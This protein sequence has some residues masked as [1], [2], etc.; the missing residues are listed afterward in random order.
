MGSDIGKAIKFALRSVFATPGKANELALLS[1]CEKLKIGLFAETNRDDKV[2]TKDVDGNRQTVVAGVA[3]VSK[4]L[5]L[6]FSALY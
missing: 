1:L 3:C 6:R 5:S 4:F 2:L